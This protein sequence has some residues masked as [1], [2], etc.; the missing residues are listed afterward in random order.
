M[1]ASFL[2]D[3][4]I[5]AG[6]KLL[7]ALREQ[8]ANPDAAFWLYEAEPAEWRLVIADADL[9]AQG[10]REGYRRIQNVLFKLADQAAPLQ[11]QDIKLR[12]PRTRLVKALRRAAKDWPGSEGVRLRN[13]LT[14]GTL[15]ED[16]YVY[17][18]S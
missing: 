14:D 12:T 4:M 8:G 10:P 3:D 18:A 9:V 6:G 1:V 16:A 13:N 15:I 7:G 11:L 5:R 17:R 2:T